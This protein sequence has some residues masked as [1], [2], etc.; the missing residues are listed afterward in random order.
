MLGVTRLIQEDFGDGQRRDRVEQV[1]AYLW[2]AIAQINPDL[3]LTYD[4][5]GLDGHRDH[6]A[7]S[8]ILT[9]LRRTQ[10]PDAS[11]WYAA[12]PGR[13]LKLLRLVGKVATDPSFEQKRTVP[14]HRF[15]IGAGVV[16]KIRS[17]YAYRS[18]RRVIGKGLGQFLPIWIPRTMLQFEYFAESV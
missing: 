1:T 5:A 10:I 2:R 11:L 18:Q 16:P 3:I 12:L 8:E 14:T 6:V 9:E 13:V 17:W 15:F 4:L 7:G